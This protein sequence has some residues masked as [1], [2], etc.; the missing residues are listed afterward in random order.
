MRASLPAELAV[1]VP[2][3]NERSNVALLVD[4]V[5]HALPDVHWEIVFVDDDS[6]DGTAQQVRALAQADARVRVVHRYGRRGLA[7]ACVEGILATSAPIVAVMDADLQHDETIL[8]AMF[9]RIRQGDVDLVVGS[10][11]VEGGGMGEWS[12]RRIAMSRLATA[13]ANR[14]TGT[15]IGDP[16]SGFFMLTRGAFM[17]SLPG[18]SS[19]GFKILL[20]IAASAPA[21]LRVAEV[22]YTFRTRQHGESK[23]D[24]LVLWEYLQLLLDKAFGHIVPARFI[25]FALVGGSG[26]VV[27]FVVLTVV[28][29]TLLHLH[30]AADEERWF[31][32]AQG[33]ATVVA[34][35]SNFFLNN[36]L[37]YRDQR[38]KG[39][40]LLWGW[41]TFNL[42]CG[43]GF[44]ANVGI[45]SWLYQRR[46]Y[47]VVSALAGIAITTVWNYAM[48]SIFTWRRRG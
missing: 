19:V 24:S 14:L 42:V 22:P 8:G 30:G 21:P 5:A 37:T 40:R 1:V 17:A 27:H 10:R 13:L 6:P 31:A 20:D 43:I 33:A 28:L 32:I 25:S 16:M 18:L 36:L 2:A 44:L 29:E 9:R 47:L 7:S 41:M 46:N 4:A 48:S 11:Y 12:R 34:T 23:L 3:Y 15:A 38:L 45:A 26:V 35:S 39:M